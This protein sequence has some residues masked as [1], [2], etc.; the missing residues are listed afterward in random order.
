MKSMRK[1][2]KLIPGHSFKIIDAGCC[3]MAGTFGLEREHAEMSVA[4]AEHALWPAL[5]EAP[6]APIVANG[7]SCRQQIEANGNR[8]ALHLAQLLRDALDDSCA[9]S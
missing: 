6:E 3:G 1:V 8:S 9:G 5:D 7:F 2:L 4:M